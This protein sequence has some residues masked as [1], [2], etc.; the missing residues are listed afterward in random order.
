[1]ARL[2]GGREY[3][4]E[5]GYSS[6]TFV[7]RCR[8]FC[9]FRGRRYDAAD[10]DR[11]QYLV[12][13]CLGTTKMLHELLAEI[14]QDT[15]KA[16]KKAPAVQ[17]FEPRTKL[18][19]KYGGKYCWESGR[20]LR[21]LRWDMLRMDEEKKD[22]LLNDIQVYCRS[23]EWFRKRSYPYKRGYLLHGPPGTGK[24][25]VVAALAATLKRS[26]YVVNV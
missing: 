6:H 7:H 10:P 17:K 9:V 18:H 16:K 3:K 25:S 15:V 22:D 11:T 23:E 12:L 24:S 21:P 5:P 19:R 13:S 20:D 26:L 14:K 2:L 1:M 4:V 8:L